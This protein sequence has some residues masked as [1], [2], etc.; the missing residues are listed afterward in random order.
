MTGFASTQGTLPDGRGFGLTIKSVNHRHLD[1]QFRLPTGLELL[2]P[3]LRKAVKSS[4]RRGHVEVMLTFSKLA[5][6][7]SLEIDEALL[8][9]YVAAFRGAAERLGLAQEPELN[10]MLRMPGV[11]GPAAA[12]PLDANAAEAQVLASFARLLEQF[13]AAR[14]AEGQALADELHAA[15]LRL[16]A[17]AREAR[18]L[19]EGIAEAEFVRLRARIRELLEHAG[20][21]QTENAIDDARLISEAGVLAARGDV[22]EELVRLRTHVGRFTELLTA[23]GEVGRPL[24][25]L[26]QELN[27]EANTMLSKTGGS[28]AGLRLTE[29]GLEMKVE[30]E[31]AREQ[32]QNLE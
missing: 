25:F 1:L 21:G 8:T 27:R 16:G 20:P 12:A 7:P 18:S 4:V 6:G 9:A 14:L 11:L 22:E 32:V 2:E 31:R 15:M 28:A 3:A 10:A 17:S 30:L 29:L 13:N 5:T 24:D 23:G 19:R 26:L